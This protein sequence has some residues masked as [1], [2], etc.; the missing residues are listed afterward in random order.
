MKVGCLDRKLMNIFTLMT[1]LLCQVLSPSM[2]SVH[3]HFGTKTLNIYKGKQLLNH[4]RWWKIFQHW[5]K[6]FNS[7][8][9]IIFGNI[10]VLF[11]DRNHPSMIG[12]VWNM[13]AVISCVV[14]KVTPRNIGIEAFNTMHEVSFGVFCVFQIMQ[15]LL[16]LVKITTRIS[17]NDF[18]FSN[19][20]FFILFIRA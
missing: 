18:F 17:R 15:L 6:V 8:W 3:N 9:K 2:Q 13:F 12:N 19:K 1:Q 10:V 4:N 20:A 7:L 11:N 14:P 5:A 16:W